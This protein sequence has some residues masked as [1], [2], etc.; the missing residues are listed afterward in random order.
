[1][2]VHVDA[3][4][5]PRPPHTATAELTG[6]AGDDASTSAIAIDETA[7]TPRQRDMPYAHPHMGMR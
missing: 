2:H 1:M 5:L 6:A 3:Q 4:H 7:R